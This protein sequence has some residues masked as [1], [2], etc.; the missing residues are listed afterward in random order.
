VLKLSEGAG[1]AYSGSGELTDG[2]GLIAGGS[3]E[4]A[5]GA[6]RLANGTGE[7]RDGSK[8]LA[9]GAGKLSEGLG[10]AA[11]GSGQ[12]ADGLDQAEEGA[13]KIVDGA[14]MLSTVGMSQLIEAGNATAQDYGKMYAVIGAAGDRAD[15]EKMAYGAPENA[16]GLTAYTFE[17]VGNDGE[18]G[19]NT[20]RG[21]LALG[22][23]GLG[24]GAFALRRRLV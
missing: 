12:L 18:G 20:T 16:Q 5:D 23:L 21:L 11:D 3:N 10:D 7:A 22:L 19:R 24:L 2:L 1:A 14:G 6:G 17:L 9:D 8:Q 4:L 15:S 13:P